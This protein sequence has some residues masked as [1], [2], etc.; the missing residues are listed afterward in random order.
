MMCSISGQV[1]METRGGQLSE[2]VEGFDTV[3]K[4]KPLCR[5]RQDG[6]HVKQIHNHRKIPSDSP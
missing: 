3:D 6:D 1:A 4:S 2:E 5:G